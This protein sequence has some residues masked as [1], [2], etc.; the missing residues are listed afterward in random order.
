MWCYETSMNQSI[1][2][3]THEMNDCDQFN[4]NNHHMKKSMCNPIVFDE[5]GEGDLI[6][7][8]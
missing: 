7:A 6:N 1:N 3:S 2:Q 4:Q 5:I 8:L